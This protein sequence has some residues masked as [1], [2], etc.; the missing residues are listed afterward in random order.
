MPEPAPEDSEDAVEVTGDETGGALATIR[1]LDPSEVQMARTF[2]SA[3]V[4]S[5]KRAVQ[6][7]WESLVA[8]RIPLVSV[9]LISAAGDSTPWYAGCSRG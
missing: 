7:S 8:L 6:W 3:S 1:E 2:G 5:N 9:G 4:R